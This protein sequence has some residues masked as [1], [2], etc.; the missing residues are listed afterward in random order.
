MKRHIG[1]KAGMI[2]AAGI[3]ALS[4]TGAFAVTVMAEDTAE[5]AGGYTGDPIT[6]NFWHTRGSGSNYEVVQHEVETFN[7]TIG[8]EK[9]ITVQETYIGDYNEMLSKTQLAIQS[10]ESPQVVVSGNTF[11]NYLLEDGVLADMAPLAEETDWDRNN[12]LDPF[13]DINGN[14][15]GTLYTV[16]YIRSTPLFYYNKTMADAKG[17]TEPTTIEE[18]EEFCKALYEDGSVSGLCIGNDFGYLQACHLYQLGSAFVSE[19]G[20]SCPALDDG[21]MLQVLSDWRRWVDEGWCEPF[22]ATDAGTVMIEEFTQQKLACL[23]NSS[24]SLSQL[25]QNAKDAGFELGA[26][27]YPTYNEDD[28]TAMIGGGNICIVSE[29]NTDDQIMASW[30]FVQF[31]MSDEEVTY[32]TE[33]T[34]YLPITKS[35][36]EY[37]GME[38]FW[39]ENPLYKVA[40]DQALTGHCQ[41]QP[42][43]PHL[44]DLT[45]A[46]WDAVSLLIADQSIDAE[47]AV[48]QIKAESE[49]YFG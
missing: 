31:L 33:M 20:N 23:I 48:E 40:Y 3:M 47:Q 26:C 24:G 41:E 2:L 9:G 44:Q 30:E 15:D 36:A 5:T 19:D 10:G 7:E 18:M 42:Y 34:G 29:G 49:S 25:M 22:D 39:N 45:Q 11:V 16:P 35:V 13:Q 14:T 4:Q 8:K 38:E 12:L 27:Q 46:C 21:T 37:E 17:L 28:R 32:N 1:K 43:S 6:I